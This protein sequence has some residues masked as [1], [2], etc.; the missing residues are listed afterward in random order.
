[1]NYN[2]DLHI[3]EF[4]FTNVFLVLFPYTFAFLIFNRTSNIYA[5]ILTFLFTVPIS[6]ALIYYVN[7]LPFN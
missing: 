3:I 6:Y 5:S 2:G 1:M 4:N 7:N